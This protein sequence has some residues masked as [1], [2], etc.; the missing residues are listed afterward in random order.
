[1]NKKYLLRVDDSTKM[2]IVEAKSAGQAVEFYFII[3]PDDRELE[4]IVYELSEPIG[5]FGI[6]KDIKPQFLR[7]VSDFIP[8]NNM[9]P[10]PALPPLPPLPPLPEQNSTTMPNVEAP[11]EPDVKTIYH[12]VVCDWHTGRPCNK[13]CDDIPF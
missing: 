10:L 7:S 9:P 3:F 2:T 13:N 12:E 6:P 8:R 5:I 11:V 1:M 4:Y